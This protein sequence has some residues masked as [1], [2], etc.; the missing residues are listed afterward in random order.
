MVPH[1]I[2]NVRFIAKIVRKIKFERIY[3]SR[4]SFAGSVRD[5]KADNMVQAGVCKHATPSLKY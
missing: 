4:N 5:M 2:E 1:F 3:K